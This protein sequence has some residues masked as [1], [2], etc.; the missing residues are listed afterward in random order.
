MI[1]MPV[2]MMM[3]TET[4]GQMMIVLT[5]NLDAVIHAI[6]KPEPRSSIQ[7]SYSIS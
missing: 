2:M 5:F 1:M 4:R 3:M 6:R 7:A